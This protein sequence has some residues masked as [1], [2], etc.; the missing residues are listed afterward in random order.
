MHMLSPCSM[1]PTLKQ[2][3][4]TTRRAIFGDP[5]TSIDG[6]LGVWI[7]RDSWYFTG[8]LYRMSQSNW[9]AR[10]EICL[11]Y[12]GQ[13]EMSMSTR[14]GECI[15]RT[16]GPRTLAVRTTARLEYDSE[17]G[18]IKRVSLDKQRQ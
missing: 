7:P 2:C 18:A 4:K 10:M 15:R 11:A 12:L 13:G 6:L 14:Y 17:V 16:V 8:D 9:P 3:A 5:L 1:E